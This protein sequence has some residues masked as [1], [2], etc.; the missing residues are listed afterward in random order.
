MFLKCIVEI[1]HRLFIILIFIVISNIQ[2]TSWLLLLHVCVC[3][4]IIVVI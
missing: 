4:F 3:M 1:T 2:V